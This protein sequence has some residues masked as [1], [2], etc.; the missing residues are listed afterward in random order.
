MAITLSQIERDV[1]LDIEKGLYSQEV[2]DQILKSAKQGTIESTSSTSSTSSIKPLGSISVIPKPV[3]IE[4]T[5]IDFTDDD[6]VPSDPEPEPEL[7]SSSIIPLGPIPTSPFP[8]TT[9]PSVESTPTIQV[10]SLDKIKQDQAIEELKEVVKDNPVV[11]ESQLQIAGITLAQLQASLDADYDRYETAVDNASS[12]LS[13]SGTLDVQKALEGDLSKA[14]F[15]ALG[16]SSEDISKARSQ[17]EIQFYLDSNPEQS[18]ILSYLRTTR[19]YSNARNAGYSDKQIDSIRELIERDLVTFSG[20]IKIE[21]ALQTRELISILRSAGLQGSVIDEV[22]V[23]VLAKQSI[24]RR[25]GPLGFI[26]SGGASSSL[27]VAGFS[28]QYIRTLN[29]L[30]PYIVSTDEGLSVD[31]VQ[32]VKDKGSSIPVIRALTDIG[33]SSDE[34]VQ[35]DEAAKSL[36]AR[37]EALRRTG[38][39]EGPSN[40]TFNALQYVGTSRNKSQAQIDL[41]ALGYPEDFTESI[42]GLVE[43]Q[44]VTKTGQVDWT[45]IEAS[46]T[47][48]RN[49]AIDLL[50]GLGVDKKTAKGILVETGYVRE[51]KP[52]VDKDGSINV[53]EVIKGR[54]GRPSIEALRFLGLSRNQIARSRGIQTAPEVSRLQGIPTRIRLDLS[55]EDRA[56]IKAL[57]SSPEYQEKRKA[58]AKATDPNRILAKSLLDITPIVGTILYA[59]EASKDGFTKSELAILAGRTLLEGAGVVPFVGAVG[60]TG[61]LAT[62]VVRGLGASAR[63][64]IAARNIGQI[65]IGTGRSIVQFPILTTRAVIAPLTAAVRLPTRIGGAI[66]KGGT[67]A[68]SLIRDPKLAVPISEGLPAAGREA[69]KVTARVTKRIQARVRTQ[70]RAFPERVRVKGKKTRAQIVNISGV[71]AS[72][73]FQIPKSTT[74]RTVKGISGGIDIGEGFVLGGASKLK[75]LSLGIK[76]TLGKDVT[77]ETAQTAIRAG[78]RGV[79]RVVVGGV[80]LVKEAATSPVSRF[81]KGYIRDTS[82]PVLH[83]FKTISGIYKIGT[84][85]VALKGSDVERYSVEA[86]QEF[87]SRSPYLTKSP[88]VSR[89][90]SAFKSRFGR[91]LPERGIGEGI[92]SAGVI[93]QTPRNIRRVIGTRGSV[94]SYTSNPGSNI[95]T[96]TLS[97]KG[98]DSIVIGLRSSGNLVE[99]TVSRSGLTSREIKGILVS[100]KSLF[101]EASQ[102]RGLSTRGAEIIQ[103]PKARPTASKFGGVIGGGTEVDVPIKPGSL[104][105][106]PFGGQPLADR[107]SIGGGQQFRTGRSIEP[108]TGREVGVRKRVDPGTS[109]EFVDITVAPTRSPTRFPTTPF[110]PTR[111]PTP[112]K[113]TPKRRTA[114]TPEPSPTTVP[115]TPSRPSRVQ[116]G[117]VPDIKVPPLPLSPFLPIKAEPLEFVD[118]VIATQ[119]TTTEVTEFGEIELPSSTDAGAGIGGGTSRI[120]RASFGQFRT[121]PEVGRLVLP[122]VSLIS[123][124]GIELETSTQPIAKPKVDFE[125]GTEVG[126]RTRTEVTP[127]SATEE[128]TEVISRPRFDT[129]AE[130]STATQIEVSPKTQVESKVEPA[131]QTT[132]KVTVKAPPFRP[133]LPLPRFRDE[134]DKPE[135]VLLSTTV[136]PFGSGSVTPG[137]RRFQADTTIVISPDS[138]PGWRF[139]HWEGDVPEGY[140]TTR[141]LAIQM[142]DNKRVVGVFIRGEETE[143]ASLRLKGIDVV[144]PTGTISREGIAHV[145]R[146]ID[147]RLTGLPGRLILGRTPIGPE[148]GRLRI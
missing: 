127:E 2:G 17:N 46:S 38:Q 122:Q 126:D 110:G 104:P 3:P 109:S 43:G 115:S 117:T 5:F 65:G 116:P 100:V 49:T 52:Y 86:I 57:V 125:I 87:A 56:S 25:G 13:R 145:R 114:P 72:S 93:R 112:F 105:R 55:E 10:V 59:K 106:E 14:D 33:F 144:L 94:L 97:V 62:P 63:S 91:F 70:V 124:E 120:A 77:V 138:G 74:I 103:L 44:F 18:N 143:L 147:R 71:V 32:L 76:S 136:S 99:A 51:L 58:R 27:E 26:K 129:I 23:T 128:D 133:T 68:P 16:V 134:E 90:G 24:E 108:T 12:Y 146:R 80:G 4:S 37:E 9:P 48:D 118:P 78:G 98:K 131:R 50:L 121:S 135:T 119:P 6:I 75:R 31:S 1:A 15:K 139:D 29:L 111:R 79:S 69:A 39:I 88:L 92:P 142:T 8:T 36:I 101:P 61:S 83:P 66:I 35:V 47:S 20:D 123:K 85:G 102:I 73:P 45:K 95:Q 113:W 34:I 140:D 82:F 54:K 130:I 89:V 28:K 11:T 67:K 81:V 42:E 132:T 22:R 137:S 96:L 64:G 53:E 30:K 84:G 141:D 19:N 60:R 41:E 40:I 21:A 107:P 148:V 7:P